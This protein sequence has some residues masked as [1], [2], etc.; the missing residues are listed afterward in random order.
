MLRIVQAASGSELLPMHVDDDDDDDD[1]KIRVL[2]VKGHLRKHYGWPRPCQRLLSDGACI[3][4]DVSVDLPAELQLVVLPFADMLK[5]MSDKVKFEEL[6]VA[7]RNG[8]LEVVRLLAEGA[9][10]VLGRD[11]YVTALLAASGSGHLDVV[12]F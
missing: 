12:Q 4:D 5:D 1:V 9:Q 10:E 11:E 2:D 3:E 8:H 6:E 7:S